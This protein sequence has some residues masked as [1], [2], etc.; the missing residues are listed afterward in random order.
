MPII[1]RTLK[2]QHITPTVRCPMLKATRAGVV[3]VAFFV[4][5]FVAQL[6]SLFAVTGGLAAALTLAI[7]FASRDVLGNLVGGVFIITNP[8]FNIGDWI[9]WNGGEES[10]NEGTIE[11]ISF[12]ATR[13]RTITNELITVPNTT[14]ATATVTNHDIKDPLRIKCSF[15]VAYGSDIDV[16]RNVLI[17]E[18]EAHPRVLRD[19]EAIVLV[20]TV[21]AAGID[22]TSLF[23]ISNPSWEKY[24]SVRSE[25][26][27]A[28]KERFEREE[29]ELSPDLLE[30]T[31]SLEADD[32]S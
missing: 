24:L 29:I 16:I 6:Q 3:I 12:R 20:E 7:G 21:T 27:Q 8:K 19:P 2:N 23:W 28:V 15:S 32:E 25:Y 18:A 4:G 30:L 11:D 1:E 13:I 5:L 10:G 14:L 9:E 31:G 17:E 22:V 26:F